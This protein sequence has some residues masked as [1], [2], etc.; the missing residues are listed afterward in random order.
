M[1]AL[2]AD[3][4]GEFTGGVTLGPHFDSGPIGDVRVVHCESIV[5]LGHGDDVA[6]AGVFKEFGPVVGIPFGSGEKRDKIFI[7][8]SVLR[9]E[10]VAVVLEGGI[11]LLV[12]IAGIPFVFRAGDRVDT[13]V[14]EDAE[15][16]VLIPL[17]NFVVAKSFPVRGVGAG[18]DLLIDVAE[19]GGAR[20]VVFG[21]GTLPF[22]IDFGGGFGGG[23]GSEWVSGLR[24]GDRS[25]EESEEEEL[26][27]RFHAQHCSAKGKEQ[28]MTRGT[29]ED[30]Q[31]Q[32]RA[33][34]QVFVVV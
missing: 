27:G 14:N 5:M 7:A 3:G 11:F 21:D 23:G 26:Q 2:G 19:D 1:Q 29:Q 34:R 10:V 13:P 25:E 20:G 12:H 30:R 9:A 6:S 33:R 22:A 16:G 15:F 31:G 17:G 32:L 28:A 4:G 18:G 24:G 8:E